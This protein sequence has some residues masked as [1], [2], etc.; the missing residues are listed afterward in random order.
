MP[1]V[2]LP[3][4]PKLKLGF[5]KK[6]L[7]IKSR[8]V[9]PPA[10]AE[11]AAPDVPDVPDRLQDEKTAALPEE[12]L[13]ECP[14][15]HDPV[16]ATNPEGILEEWV[17]LNCG[18]KFGTHCIQTWLQESAE[19]DPYSTPTCPICRTAAKHHCGHPIVLPANRFAPFTSVWAPLQP[20]QPP[21][22][23]PQL[24][25][26]RT[27]RRLSRRPSHPHRPSRTLQLDRPRVQTVGQC[28][29][30][31]AVEERRMR[32]Q[33]QHMAA[34]GAET[35]T[36]AAADNSGRGRGNDRRTTG[37]KSML[38]QTSLRRLSISNLESPRGEAHDVFQTPNARGTYMVPREYANVC[39][40]TI[41]TGGRSSTPAPINRISTF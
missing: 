41:I 35:T 3:K 40:T 18:H 1:G 7:H 8:P 5:L 37:I 6:L 9:E 25:R 2:R 21:V 29:I 27:R 13:E 24:E 14:I 33:Q 4:L 15:C 22:L 20:P 28:R 38:L 39:R 16:G 31:A 26:R 10:V 32:Q 17:H 12:P 34:P 36:G 19:R 30:C 11:P 23:A